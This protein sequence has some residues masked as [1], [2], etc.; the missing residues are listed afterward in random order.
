MIW[1]FWPWFDPAWSSS[2]QSGMVWSS[3][4]LHTQIE[5]DLT[6]LTAKFKDKNLSCIQVNMVHVQVYILY[7]K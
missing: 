4:V 7:S 6:Y 1:H 3:S 2:E 5:D